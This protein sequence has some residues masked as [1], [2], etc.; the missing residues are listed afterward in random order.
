MKI[1]T[2]A[3]C[4]GLAACVSGGNDLQTLCLH[5]DPNQMTD[6]EVEMCKAYLQRPAIYQN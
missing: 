5:K 2:I 4:L 6:R 1:F 3:L